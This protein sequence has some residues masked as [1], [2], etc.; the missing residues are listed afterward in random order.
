M[1]RVAEAAIAQGFAPDTISSDLHS[2]VR[3]R[4]RTALATQHT[5]CTGMLVDMSTCLAVQLCTVGI[6]A[7]VYLTLRGVEQVRHDLI[8]ATP[9]GP[10]HDLCVDLPTTITQQYSNTAIQ[11]PLPTPTESTL[12]T[13]I[14]RAE[15]SL[16]VYPDSELYTILIRTVNTHR[17]Y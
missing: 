15:L 9:G 12:C 6:N 8:Q 16:Y 13:Y 3:T 5:D 14:P 1:G 11:P 17:R 2:Q 10:K 7:W 4:G